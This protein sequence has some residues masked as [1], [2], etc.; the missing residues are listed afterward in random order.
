MEDSS[1]KLLTGYRENED[2]F[3]QDSHTILVRK[4]SFNIET[5]QRFN[6]EEVQGINHSSYSTVSKRFNNRATESGL[7]TTYPQGESCENS[8]KII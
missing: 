2:D 4:G 3:R 1:E 5:M 8:Q 6:E 7:M